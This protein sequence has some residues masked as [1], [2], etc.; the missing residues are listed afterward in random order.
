MVSERVSS[1]SIGMDASMVDSPRTRAW[2]LRCALIALAIQ[3][4]TP[5]AQDVTSG[6]IWRIL[7]SIASD[8]IPPT[9]DEAPLGDDATHEKPGEVCMPASSSG[10]RPVTRHS[11]DGP[12]PP[13]RMPPSPCHS[14]TAL[15][16]RPSP[17][18]AAATARR[19]A[20]L[21]R[22]TC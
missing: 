15:T 3:G 12:C 2:C 6:S 19:L 4:M 1:S 17:R 9:G 20:S 7:R 21:G 16:R 5:D 13:H 11:I 14:P 18:D 8:G 22:L 10:V